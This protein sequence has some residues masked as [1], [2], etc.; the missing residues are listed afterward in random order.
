MYQTVLSAIVA[1]PAHAEMVS[2][3]NNHIDM[4]DSALTKTM[5]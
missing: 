1:E 5:Y 4:Y 2:F 3:M